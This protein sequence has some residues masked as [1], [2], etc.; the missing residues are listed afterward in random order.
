MH[1]ARMGRSA[2]GV[3]V[4]KPEGKR[5]LERNRCRREDDIKTY[6]TDR[7]GVRG[8]GYCSWSCGQVACTCQN[9]NETSGYN[10][11]RR[12]SGL[13]EETL[14]WFVTLAVL[15]AVGQFA[16]RTECSSFS[17]VVCCRTCRLVTLFENICVYGS[18][19]FS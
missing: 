9:G 18:S 8:L 15:H 14:R 19:T 1:T 17:T 16:T 13:A 5:P 11:T 12:F 7:L 4:G 10:K 2:Y 3:L 6:V